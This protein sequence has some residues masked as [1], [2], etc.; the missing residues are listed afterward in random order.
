[1]NEEEYVEFNNLLTKYRVIVLK[2]I[3]K[4]QDASANNSRNLVKQLRSTDYLRNNMIHR[5]KNDTDEI[6]PNEKVEN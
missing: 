2:E 6:K 1:M 5:F 3:A 4:M